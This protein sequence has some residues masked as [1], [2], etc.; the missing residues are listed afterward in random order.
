MGGNDKRMMYPAI[1]DKCG[2]ACNVP[3]K[4]SGNK[5]VYCSNCFEKTGSREGQYHKRETGVRRYGGFGGNR[6][7]R[8]REQNANMG[9]QL[10]L[11]NAK[12]EQIITLLKQ[13]VPLVTDQEKTETKRVKKS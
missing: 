3:F 10:E 4:P 7:P 6:P 2:A 11:L 9:T 12:L 13:M 8:D 5:P 1:C